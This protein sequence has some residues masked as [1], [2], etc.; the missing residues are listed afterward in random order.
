MTEWHQRDDFWEAMAPKI[1][2]RG[3][4]DA[5][6][7]EVDNVVKLL[8]ISP[9]D[10]VLDLCCGPGRHSIELARRG[11]RVTGVDRYPPYLEEARSR[12]K[13]AGVDIELVEED[14]RRFCRPVGFDAA[15]NLYSSFGY[16]EDLEDDE[17]VLENIYRSLRDGGRLAMDM[18]G[19]EVIARIFRER[20]WHEQDG[21]LF[22][23]ERELSDDWGWI[24]NR[25][26]RIDGSG[27][28]EFELSLRLFSGSELAA[29][30]RG[31]GFASVKLFGDLSGAPYDQNA[32]RLVAVARR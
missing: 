5:A 22:L 18:M 20:D 10:S 31:C 3:H 25:W 28:E 32:S 29:L 7:A 11:F 4:W 17:Q 8:G 14:M 6:P 21:V 27:R 16:F 9:G 26:I 2:T 1:F 12:A 30:L 24:H 13:S 23:E 19:K 15:L